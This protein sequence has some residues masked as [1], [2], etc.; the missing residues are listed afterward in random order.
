M[1]LFG[2]AD[3]ATESPAPAA[4]K[5]NVELEI[6]LILIAAP[7]AQVVVAIVPDA[8]TVKQL[9]P[10]VPSAEMTTE[11]AKVEVLLKF[12]AALKVCAAVHATL[13]A[14]VTKPGFTN[15]SV[16][17][18]VEN[19]RFEPMTAVCKVPEALELIMEEVT[20]VSCVD[21]LNVAVELNVAPLLKVCAAVHATELAAVIKPGFTKE[22]TML[23]P[24]EVETERMLSPVN[25]N[26]DD[27]MPLIAV[28][29]A[30]PP[31]EPQS[32]PVPVITPF[33]ACKHC[34]PVI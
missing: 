27:A 16:L 15:A 32:E 6:P 29:D 18:E 9:F 13:E 22:Y 26:C 23:G 8:F 5:L 14:A 28:V 34:V 31:A 33:T 2:F 17:V 1:I 11:L 4:R 24:A 20:A 25:V 3:D 7:A 19:V 30:P 21:E 10:D 12:A